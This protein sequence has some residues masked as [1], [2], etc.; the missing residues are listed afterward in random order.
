M[1]DAVVR[2]VLELERLK[3]V[4]RKTKVLVEGHE[5]R[6]ENSAEHSWQIAM[7][8]SA[9]A[10]F[11]PTGAGS[12]DAPVSSD[13]FDMARV[14]GM[15]LVHDVG[16][17]DTGDTL[18]YV[19]EGEAERKAAERRAVERIFGLLP[20][21]QGAPYLALWN[22]FEEGR[23][24]EARFAHAADRAMPALLNLT[25]GGQSWVEHGI[26]HERVLR[27]IGPPIEAGCPALWAWMRERLD[28]ELARGWFGTLQEAPDA[29]AR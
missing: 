18:V 27:R 6:F 17:I 7:L 24:P 11:A 25:H 19:E 12:A 14:I 1:I 8:A 9:L 23:T 21:G 20:D 10:P 22:E 16:E 13:G 26:T 5:V 29:R 28:E 4:T 3:A 15:L 2:F